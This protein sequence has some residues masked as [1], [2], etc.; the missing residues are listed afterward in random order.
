MPK[1]LEHSLFPAGWWAFSQHSL[2]CSQGRAQEAESAVGECGLS[3]YFHGLSYP[4]SARLAERQNGKELASDGGPLTEHQFPPFSILPWARRKAVVIAS[5]KTKGLC[6]SYW[7]GV[8]EGSCGSPVRENLIEWVVVIGHK[9]TVL[10][11]ELL[12]SGIWPELETVW[13]GICLLVADMD[14]SGSVS[15][16]ELFHFSALLCSERVRIR[17]VNER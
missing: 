9:S 16:V 6:L 4:G 1:L 8:F 2:K 13:A 12:D 11:G 17:G 14:V 5:H 3:F 7:Q 10:M 15:F